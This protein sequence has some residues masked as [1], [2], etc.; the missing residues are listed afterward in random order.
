MQQR[1]VWAAE[2]LRQITGRIS[3]LEDEAVKM[4]P[5]MIDLARQTHEFSCAADAKAF[6]EGEGTAGANRGE[7]CD[8]NNT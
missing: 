4:A 3:K 1:K 6:L 8:T 2:L 5:V 7:E